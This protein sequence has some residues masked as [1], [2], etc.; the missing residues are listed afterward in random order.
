MNAALNSASLET[1]ASSLL[2]VIGLSAAVV[3]MLM[4]VA[5]GWWL[6]G[7][8]KTAFANHPDHHPLH[9]EAEHALTNLH[10][11]THQVKTDVGAHSTEVKA[12]SNELSAAK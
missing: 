5:L 11:L 2:V 12:I 1:A 10:E 3:E 9:A 6:R 8:K 4:G 7:G